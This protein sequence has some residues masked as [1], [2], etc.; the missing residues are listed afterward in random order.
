MHIIRNANDEDTSQICFLLDQLGYNQDSVQFLQIYEN[1]LRSGIYNCLVAEEETKII[2]IGVFIIY[3]L[4]YKNFNH[5]SLEVLVV[6][7]EYR[8]RRIGTEMIKKVEEIAKEK[9]CSSISL[10]SNMHRDKKVHEFY[11]R[12]GYN[13]KGSSAQLYLKKRL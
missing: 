11:L 5:C 1:C 7:I 2:A 8:N 6:D 13:N 12:N 3:P 9:N 10:I 4:F